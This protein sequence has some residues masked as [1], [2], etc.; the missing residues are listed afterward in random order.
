MLVKL[1]LN[2]SLFYFPNSTTIFFSYIDLYSVLLHVSVVYFSH[3]QLG[4]LVHKKER[5]VLTDIGYKIILEFII[6][7]INIITKTE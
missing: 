2:Q 7:I 1:A 6:I 3:R 4:I 5:P